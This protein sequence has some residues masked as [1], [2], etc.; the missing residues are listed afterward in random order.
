VI[1]PGSPKQQIV[2]DAGYNRTI[3]FSVD[4]R[5]VEPHSLGVAE[6][7]CNR[8]HYALAAH[9]GTRQNLRYCPLCHNGNRSHTSQASSEATT[10]TRMPAMIHRIHGG[11][12]QQY[13]A[14]P[15]DCSVCHVNGS[16]ELPDLLDRRE[17][18]MASCSGC[19]G[20]KGTSGHAALEIGASAIGACS[21]C[22]GPGAQSGVDRVHAR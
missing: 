21:T 15:R 8:C 20:N 2:K 17:A 3:D 9:E 16:L 5:L 12:P 4:N 19:H 11:D 22:H 1:L 14:D 13:P 6:E 18:T 7:Q 10:A